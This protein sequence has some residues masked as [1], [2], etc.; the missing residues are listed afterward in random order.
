MLKQLVGLLPSRWLNHVAVSETDVSDF[1]DKIPQA[2]VPRNP[3]PGLAAAYGVIP[4]NIH[5]LLAKRTRSRVRVH[6]LTEETGNSSA[7]DFGWQ[8]GVLTIRAGGAGGEP[9][10]SVRHVKPI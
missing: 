8:D 5:G 1:K 10:V 6:R 9:R 7:I 3:I 4:V 2:V